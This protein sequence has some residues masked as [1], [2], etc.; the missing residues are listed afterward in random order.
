[1]KR[2]KILGIRDWW[3]STEFYGILEN[4]LNLILKT[5]NLNFDN[6]YIFEI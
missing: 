5:L 2:W 6:C 4:A 1:M 3:L